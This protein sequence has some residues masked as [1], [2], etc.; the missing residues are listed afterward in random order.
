[1]QKSSI[2]N[3]LRKG[4]TVFTFKDILLSSNETNPDLL[5]R[6]IHYYVKNRELY[7]IRKGIYAKDKNYDRMELANK[8]YT[9]SYISLETVLSQE[10]VVFQHY[11]QIFVVSYLTREITCDGQKYGFRKVKDRIL[12]NSYG[13]EKR[14]HYFIASRERAFL[15]TVYLNKNYYF[16]NLSSIDWDRCFEMLPIYKNKAMEKRLN[17]CHKM[18]KHA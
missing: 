4:N 6:R 18:A 10:G 5:K 13:I 15:D 14:D 3:I 11:E 9:P 8:I 17:S 7:P 12:T 2:L 16:D 1:M